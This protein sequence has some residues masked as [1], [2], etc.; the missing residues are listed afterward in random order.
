MAAAIQLA[1]S[2]VEKKPKEE[3]GSESFRRIQSTK[4]AKI[5]RGVKRAAKQMI[6]K[7]QMKALTSY[8]ANK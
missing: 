1:A 5:N 8:F 6:K 3:S 2:K 4:E 7:K